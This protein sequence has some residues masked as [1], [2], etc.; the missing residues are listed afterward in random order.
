MFTEPVTGPYPWP[1][2]SNTY[3]KLYFRHI[4]FNIIFSPTPRPSDT[5]F[6][7]RFTYQNFLSISHPN[8]RWMP[9]PSLPPWRSA[10]LCN[11]LQ[12]SI[13]PF[14]LVPQILRTLSFS[15]NFRR[16]Y[17]LK[18]RGNVS[19]PYKTKGKITVLYMLIFVRFA[20]PLC[21]QWSLDK[22]LHTSEDYLGAV[23]W[24]GSH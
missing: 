22:R 5:F 9:R 21:P 24:L 10:S 13:T 12:P 23:V 16:C 15:E 8:P 3:Q 17:S 2:E 7:F 11:F 14:L 1:D 19:H 18:T 4:Y 20:L 6:P